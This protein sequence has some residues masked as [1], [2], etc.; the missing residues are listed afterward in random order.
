MAHKTV[1]HGY[2]DERVAGEYDEV[3]FSSLVGRTFDRLEKRTLRAVVRKTVNHFGG[4]PSVLDL[5]CGTGR[6]TELLLD[7]GLTVIGGDISE[8]MMAVAGRKLARF[9]DR[10]SFRR[11]D[12]DR[13]EMGDN[14]VD[15]VTCIR[16]LHHLDS[17]A[18]AQILKELARVSRRYVLINV[19]FSSP[20]YALRRRLKMLLGQGISA[21][22]ST[23]DE[24]RREA[25][26]AGLRIE[27]SKFVLPLAT[28]DL[29]VLLRKI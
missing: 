20:V 28:E 2:V 18:R 9:G 16:L 13:L 6:I 10:V 24:I 14:S 5:P 27:S 15:L 8:A 12:I 22:S 21:S 4:R 17:N 19:A 11:L 1:K 23:W 29:V 25:A 26:E 7:E 3:R